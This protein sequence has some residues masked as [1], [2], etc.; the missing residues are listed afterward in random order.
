[1][2]AQQAL[3]ATERARELLRGPVRQALD[4]WYVID[5][6]VCLR[7]LSAASSNLA[8]RWE[9]PGQH[10]APWV[11]VDGRPLEEWA[12]EW[13]AL[14]HELRELHELAERRR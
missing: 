3:A 4:D 1:M 10:C 8:R 7:P 13:R 9:Q 2:Q 6:G 12:Q 11:T 14:S 5:G